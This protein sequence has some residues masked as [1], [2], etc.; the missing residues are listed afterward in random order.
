MN[1]KNTLIS[2]K[3]Y[4]IIFVLHTNRNGVPSK[5]TNPNLIVYLLR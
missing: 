4:I 1:D 3:R 2:V 5:I